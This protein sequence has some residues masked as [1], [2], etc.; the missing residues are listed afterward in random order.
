MVMR[1]NRNDAPQSIAL[2]RK[3]L[4]YSLIAKDLASDFILA[5]CQI[6]G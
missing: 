3:T 2:P 5:L 4:R 6:S 1:M